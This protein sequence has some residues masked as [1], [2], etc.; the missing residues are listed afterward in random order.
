MKL[1]HDGTL[2]SVGRG[3]IFST[4]YK[5][6]EKW[7]NNLTDE[8]HSLSAPQEA[9]RTVGESVL[10]AI[11]LSMLRTPRSFLSQSF[12]ASRISVSLTRRS[13]WNMDGSASHGSINE[14]PSSMSA[15]MFRR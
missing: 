13:P 3:G 8:P 2:P 15:A 5:N 1:A 12:M 4:I 11:S 14:S 7:V 9:L 10:M 6:R